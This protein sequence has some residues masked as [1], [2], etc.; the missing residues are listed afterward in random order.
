[1]KQIDNFAKFIF[2]AIDADDDFTL[3][4]L[5]EAGAAPDEKSRSFPIPLHQAVLRGNTQIVELL[6]I[7]G[8]AIDSECPVIAATPLFAA[9]ALGHG[10]IARTLIAN[11]ADPNRR[12]LLGNTPL[13]VAVR[14]AHWTIAR[15]L[16]AAG[17]EIHAQNPQR[18]TILDI[19][20]QEMS[21]ILQDEFQMPLTNLPALH[22]GLAS[23]DTS[24]ERVEA[25]ASVFLRTDRR[26]DAPAESLA[27][28][29]SRMPRFI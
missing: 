13:M 5:L 26:S 18:I 27:P 8:A 11:G 4:G 24:V 22:A 17:A 2:L 23:V 10:T 3:A 19:N 7:Y 21:R 6:V 15:A 29:L 14:G 28:S 20:C 1:M 12:D 16:I 9:S 25:Q